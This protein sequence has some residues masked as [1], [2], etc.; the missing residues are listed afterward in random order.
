MEP[1]GKI[2]RS[3]AWL[4]AVNLLL[5]SATVFAAPAARVEFAIGSVSVETADGRVRPL[6][7]GATVEE[8]ETVN[9]NEGRAQLRFTDDGFISLHS[10]TV[11]R[12][13]AYRWSGVTDGSE[14]AVFRLVKGGLR[15]ITGKLAKINKKAYQMSSQVA[16]IGVRGTEYTMQANGDLTG[17]VTE[18]E[19]EV[20]NAGGCV[21]VPA[22]QSYYVANA[23]TKPTLSN[24][25][26]N[27][28]PLQPRDVRA[29]PGGTAGAAL[30]SASGL[31][32][33]AGDRLGVSDLSAP[34]PGL[35][36]KLDA[37]SGSLLGTVN[38]TANG[39]IGFT[40]GTATSLLDATSLRQPVQDVTKGVET[41]LTNT[42]TTL[43][44]T[45]AR[46]L[47]SAGTLTT[48]AIAPVNGVTDTLNATLNS[49]LK[50]L[51]STLDGTLNGVTGSNGL[52]GVLKPAR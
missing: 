19:I 32:L 13:D 28:A 16:T 20:C 26:V 45:T 18:G 49:P 46:V 14:S 33:E 4:A 23:S 12:I 44:A 9:T 30:T 39:V 1:L 11:F 8:G 17:S 3:L 6:L 7:K 10:Q 24:K 34:N 52:L 35:G 22:G 50:T 43:G 5:F 29:L 36:N 37:R 51:N 41:V 15:T 21:A 2:R 25:Q 38:T 27:L 42:T 48:G 31:V 40:Q 47:E